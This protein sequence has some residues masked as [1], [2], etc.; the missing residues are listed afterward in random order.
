MN[1]RVDANIIQSFGQVNRLSAQLFFGE[2]KLHA[3]EYL[4]QPKLLNA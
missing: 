3:S 4:K 2:S 1:E